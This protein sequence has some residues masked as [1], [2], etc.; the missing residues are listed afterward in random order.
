MEDTLMHY[1]ILGMKWGVRRTPEQLGHVKSSAKNVAKRVTYSKKKDP[2]IPHYNLKAKDVYKNM[3]QMTDKE[4][5][6]ALNRL[7]WQKEAKSLA[8]K[9]S[10]VKRGREFLKD[11]T[12]TLGAISAAAVITYTMSNKLGIGVPPIIELLGK[13]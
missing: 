3:D 4:L 1:G 7:Q 5:R 13:K 2:N 12:A 8:S 11:Y 9:P 6:T 10:T